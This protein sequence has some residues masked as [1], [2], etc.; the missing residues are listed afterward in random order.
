MMMK[1]NLGP[2]ILTQKQ[3]QLL[4]RLILYLNHYS[5]N[6]S[7]IQKTLGI[8]SGWIIDQVVDYTIGASKCNP[9]AGSSYFKLPKE[10][11]HPYNDL[12]DIQNMSD[13]EC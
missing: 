1:Q 2:F 11:N 12:I 13:D 7:N 3:K 5:T 10:L 4:I 9:V 8:G 6:I